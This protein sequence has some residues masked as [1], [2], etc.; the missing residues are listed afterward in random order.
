MERGVCEGCKQILEFPP[1]FDQVN[2]ARCHHTTKFNLSA[3]KVL[4]CA[5]CNT[6][7]GYPLG[8]SAVRCPSCDT[9][10]G[11]DGVELVQTTC[12]HCSETLQHPV[13]AQSVKCAACSGLTPIIGQYLCI[14]NP[15]NEIV[16][17]TLAT[18]MGSKAT[19]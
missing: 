15:D 18:A 1:G 10:T 7:L 12:S 16:Y 14:C 3:P 5:K 11:M 19:V 8:A 13:G 17:A 6:R 9:I 2:C 4:D